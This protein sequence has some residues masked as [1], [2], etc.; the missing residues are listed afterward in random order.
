M[1]RCLRVLVLPRPRRPEAGGAPR[2]LDLIPLGHA[3]PFPEKR[4]SERPPY[5][6]AA[7]AG[8]AA[9]LPWERDYAGLEG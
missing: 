4:P 9:T 6:G 5:A 8:G 1:S 2:Q 3:G 7:L